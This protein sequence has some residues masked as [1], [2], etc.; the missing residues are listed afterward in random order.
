MPCILSLYGRWLDVV[1]PYVC[2]RGAYVSGAL[3]QYKDK[4]K[5]KD[6]KRIWQ[7]AYMVVY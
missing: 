5:D 1:T 2:P 6:K 4:D 7:T 3:S